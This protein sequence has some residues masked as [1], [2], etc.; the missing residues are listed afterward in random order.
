MRGLQ[1]RHARVVRPYGKV[2]LKTVLPICFW[3]GFLVAMLAPLI[4]PAALTLASPLLCGGTLEQVNTP[5]SLPAESGVASSFFCVT[6]SAR[7]E[8]ST[9][10]LIAANVAAYMAIA[11]AVIA[12]IG[13]IVRRNLGARTGEPVPAIMRG[14]FAQNIEADGARRSVTL[15]G[16]DA[17]EFLEGLSGLIDGADITAR[18]SETID[19][20][21]ADLD[22]RLRTVAGLRAQGLIDDEAYQAIVAK[23]REKG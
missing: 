17:D 23:I 1:S 10:A 21:D 18:S 3:I 4:Y 16:R 15:E 2:L 20:R 11:L 9:L 19:L 22:T 12:P 5:Y 7:T 6:E 14:H 13:L 8:L